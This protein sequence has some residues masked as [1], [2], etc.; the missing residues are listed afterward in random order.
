MAVRPSESMTRQNGQPTA[1]WSAPVP[2]AS[3][4]RFRLIRS[5]MV[6]HPHPGTAGAAAEG[7][8]GVALHLDELGTG[9]HLQQLARGS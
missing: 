9:E 4:V 6:L 1:I 3:V 2:T 5:P 8:L 7:A